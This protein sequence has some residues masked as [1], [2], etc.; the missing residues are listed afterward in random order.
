MV[1]ALADEHNGASI[2]GNP[3]ARW[4]YT[5]IITGEVSFRNQTLDESTVP[6]Q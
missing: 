2:L 6:W 3:D 5:E 1:E 4:E